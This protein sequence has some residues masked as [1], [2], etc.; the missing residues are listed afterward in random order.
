[1]EF[2]VDKEG[3]DRLQEFMSLV[4]DMNKETYRKLYSMRMEQKLFTY[5][6]IMIREREIEGM[7]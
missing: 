2:T 3:K 1:M 5:P 6:P 4:R 7:K